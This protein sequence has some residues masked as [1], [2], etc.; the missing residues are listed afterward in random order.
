MIANVKDFIKLHNVPKEL[1]ERVLDYITSSW[2]LTKGVDTDMNSWLSNVRSV[3]DYEYGHKIG[4]SYVPLGMQRTLVLNFS[5]HGNI[6][7]LRGAPARKTPRSTQEWLKFWPRPGLV[8]IQVGFEARLCETISLPDELKPDICLSDVSMQS[9]VSE[10][11][12][13]RALRSR[14]D[15]ELS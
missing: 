3:C 5:Y 12:D 13:C 15:A 6:I 8:T 4:S 2:S 14:E 10:G 1:A 9:L 11:M 7:K